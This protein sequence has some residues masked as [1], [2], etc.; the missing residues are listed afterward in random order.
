MLLLRV[1]SIRGNSR[2][3]NED[4]DAAVKVF[5]DAFALEEVDVCGGDEGRGSAGYVRELVDAEGG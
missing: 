3:S 2:K 5:D 4:S 1:W